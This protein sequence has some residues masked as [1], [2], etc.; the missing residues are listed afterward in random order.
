MTSQLYPIKRPIAIDLF[1][2]AGGMSLGFEQAGFDVILG[3]DFDGHHIASHKRN[4]PLGRA[5]CTSVAGLTAAQIRE[6]AGCNAEIDLLFGG[7][8]CQGFSNMGHRDTSDPRNTMVDEFVRIAMELQP[9]CVVMENVPGMIAGKTRAVLDRAL[10]SLSQDYNITSPVQVLNAANYGVPQDRKRVFVMAVRKDIA[11]A[12]DYP[13][14]TTPNDADKVTVADAILDLPSIE[15]YDVLYNQN[16]IKY[17]KKP[18]SRYA[19]IARGTTR[20]TSDL[21]VP[22]LWDRKTCTGCTR[23][24]HAPN[25][26]ELYKATAPGMTVPGHK[27]PRLDPNGLCPTLRAGSDSTRGSYTSPRPVHPFLP[28]CLSV[29]ESARLHGYPDWFSFVPTKWHAYKQI[30]NSVCPPV[31]RAVGRVLLDILNPPRTT[32]SPKSVRLSNVFDIPEDRP[33]QKARIPQM[34]EFP[35]VITQLFRERF[36]SSNNKLSRAKFTFED[37]KKAIEQTGVN[38]S[39]VR[40]DTFLQEIARSRN[41]KSI[42][43]TPLENGYSIKAHVK[44]EC[45]GEFV[46]SSDGDTIDKKDDAG[47]KVGDMNDPVRT[48]YSSPAN[49]AFGTKVE[50]FLNEKSVRTT[51]WSTKVANIDVDGA[52]D[53]AS[54]KALRSSPMR[55]VRTAGTS[56]KSLLVVGSDGN[57][58]QPSRI[59]RF[60]KNALSNEVVTVTRITATH[61]LASR[62]IH[63]KTTPKEISRAV[64]LLK[65]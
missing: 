12:V 19:K 25:T 35:P 18:Q 5:V 24:K 23:T 27:L 47:V 13:R 14:A 10:K 38:L 2:G 58:P 61:V 60:A 51:I 17:D 62:Y 39:W 41:V 8:P 34:R 9:K 46:P 53:T 31:A 48:S 1:C 3:I 28:R 7:P 52:E 63:C 54:S 26:V 50:G 11:A 36:N 49:E 40:G 45:I 64:F 56:T 33:R 29:R 37:V 21:S 44:K 43:A 42:L 59:S 57:V 4:F 32:D 30:G 15:D 16:E 55:V 22:R 65:A 6:Y 20:D